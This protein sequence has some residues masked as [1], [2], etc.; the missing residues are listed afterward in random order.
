MNALQAFP[1]AAWDDISAAALD[2]EMVK[3]ARKLEIA[4]AEKK[5]VWGNTAEVSQRKRLEDS[6][7]SMDRHQQK[8]TT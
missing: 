8:G 4:Y 6:S 7:I 5:P 3:A 1:L 2:P